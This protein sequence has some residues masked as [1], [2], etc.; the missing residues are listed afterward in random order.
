MFS[1]VIGQFVVFIY[2]YIIVGITTVVAKC[3]N[4]S[5]EGRRH[6]QEAVVIVGDSMCVW[7]V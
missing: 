5:W 4:R 1:F 7:C 6:H 2:Y 3:R